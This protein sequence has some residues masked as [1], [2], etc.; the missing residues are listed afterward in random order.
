M[1]EVRT[2]RTHKI[3]KRNKN[4]EQGFLTPE[5]RERAE[6]SF[7]R[8]IVP[9]QEGNIIRFETREFETM[10]EAWENMKKMAQVI[11]ILKEQQE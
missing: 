8:Q 1:Q 5:M 10:D 4:M 11:D 7:R 2:S 6:R 9:I 3:E